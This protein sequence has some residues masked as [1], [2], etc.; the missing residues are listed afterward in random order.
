MEHLYPLIDASRPA[1]P[2]PQRLWNVLRIL[3]KSQEREGG[4]ESVFHKKADGYELQKEVRFAVI[5]PDKPDHYE[6]SLENDQQ[7][8]F[9][10]IPLSY[11]K[12]VAV[13]LSD[14]EFD[15]NLKLTIRF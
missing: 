1:F 2:Y 15:A 10:L 8:G 14:L 6:L 3:R 5:C 9:T 12:D 11:G 7:L 13:E 4:L